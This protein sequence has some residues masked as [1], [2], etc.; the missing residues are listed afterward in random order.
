[1]HVKNSVHRGGG[2][3]CLPQCLRAD[4]PRAD[5]PGSRHPLPE[6]TLPRSRHTPPGADPP[7]SRL[8]RTVNKR[9]VRILLECI[10]VFT[11]FSDKNIC[12]YSERARTCHLLCWNQGCYH[13]NSQTHVRN[14]IFKMTPIL[15][16]LIYQIPWIRWMQWIPVPFRENSIENIHHRSLAITQTTM[17][18]QLCRR[19][20]EY[21]CRATVLTGGLVRFIG[22]SCT[23]NTLRLYH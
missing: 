7:E 6:Q 18:P 8:Q 5:P 15:A 10:L 11:E 20:I 17:Q 13:F 19:W 16:S 3:G 14:R 22:K 4:P 2:A 21:K 1:M 12:Y 23:V 9:L